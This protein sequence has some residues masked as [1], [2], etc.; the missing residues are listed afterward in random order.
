[1]KNLN[2]KPDDFLQYILETINK[3]G[4]IIDEKEFSEYTEKNPEVWDTDKYEIIFYMVQEYFLE[5]MS[6]SVYNLD[7]LKQDIVLYFNEKKLA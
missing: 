2:L 5:S 6:R 4:D 7:D 1:M 3:T